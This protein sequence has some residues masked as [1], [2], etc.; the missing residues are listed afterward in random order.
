[1]SDSHAARNDGDKLYIGPAG[2]Y[3]ASDG[4]DLIFYDATNAAE[5]TLSETLT[6]AIA[7]PVVIDLADDAGPGL[8]VTNPDVTGDT[9]AVEIIPS[10]AGAGIAIT[11]QEVDTQAVLITTVASGAVSLLDFD[12]TTGAGWIGADGEGAIRLTSDGTN[13]HANASLINIVKTGAT[14]AAMDGSCLRI[15]DASTGGATAGYA[16]SINASG[17]LEALHVDAGTVVVDETVQ[18]LGGIITVNAE[19][20]IADPPTQANMDTAF[21]AGAAANDGMLG[22]INDAGA[23]TNVWLCVNTN[24]AWYYAAKLTIGA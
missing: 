21:G 12:L 17:A 22:V 24:G 7:S 8:S 9:N 13:A 18:A 4:D 3:I 20:D 2:S 14:V 5:K 16:V 19:T 1:M 6:T 11:P 10:G 23:G 15:D